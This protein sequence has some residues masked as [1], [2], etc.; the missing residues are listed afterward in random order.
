MFDDVLIESA[1]IDKKKGGW[2]TASV[3]GIIHIVVIGAAVAAGVYAK[4]KPAEVEKPIAAFFVSA[5]PP[6]PPP[7]PAASHAQ[8]QVAH[9]ETPKFV[10]KFHQP[11]K[12]PKEVPQVDT[13]QTDTTGGVEGGVVGGQA[14][15]V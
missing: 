9:V 4:T 7:P 5:P 10:P 3:S 14:G 2:R 12:V 8:T 6:P 13:S 11:T 15:G 1:G